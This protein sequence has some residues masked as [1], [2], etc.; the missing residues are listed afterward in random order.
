MTI[1]RL[2]NRALQF[3]LAAH[4]PRSPLRSVVAAPEYPVNSAAAQRPPAAL[5]AASAHV[6]LC[7]APNQA[8]RSAPHRDDLD[9]GP[10]AFR[11]T[12][13][14]SGPATASRCFAVFA[15]FAGNYQQTTSRPLQQCWAFGNSQLR[16]QPAWPL[17]SQPRRKNDRRGI[18]RIHLCVQL[19]MMIRIPRIVS[20]ITMY[21]Q[22]DK[23][24][25]FPH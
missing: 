11:N 16:K 5:S 18:A 10:R 20:Y 21:H 8:V 4:L 25:Y 23:L 2:A 3:S 13:K 1:D 7:P 14:I 17:F 24:Y 12:R 22:Y 19:G 15:V 9:A 6:G